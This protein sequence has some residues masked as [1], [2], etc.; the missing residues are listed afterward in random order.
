MIV[1]ITAILQ[2][3]DVVNAVLIVGHG[4][5]HIGLADTVNRRQEPGLVLIGIFLAACGFQG[6]KILVAAGFGNGVSG[7]LVPQRIQRHVGLDLFRLKIP[8]I[9][10]RSILIPA[11]EFIALPDGIGRLLELLAAVDGHS[12]TALKGNGVG[13]AGTGG[14]QADQHAQGQQ[15]RK[16]FLVHLCLLHFG[17]EYF[18]TYRGDGF[19][20][21]CK[22][23]MV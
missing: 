13:A 4:V 5:A 8:H 6:R 17:A 21:L 10:H 12:F 14:K 1:G 22:A 20:P 7:G 15:D 16:K 11:Q 2:I 19:H 9:G 3:I 23:F 18:C